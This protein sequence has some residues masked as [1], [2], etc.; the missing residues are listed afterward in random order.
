MGDRN[1]SAESFAVHTNKILE[2]YSCL[3]MSVGT[4]LFNLQK[5]LVIGPKVY[6]L[7][8]ITADQ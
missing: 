6:R 2:F 7:I 1:F 5:S 8:V 3:F 4:Y